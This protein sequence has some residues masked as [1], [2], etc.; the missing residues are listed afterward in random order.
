[1]VSLLIKAKF[2]MVRL[3]SMAASYHIY[4]RDLIH[5]IAGIRSA[6]SNPFRP[7]P[8]HDRCIQAGRRHFPFILDVFSLS[9]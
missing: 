9:F 2:S 6:C 5:Y 7:I 3:F 8:A 4:H 1:M